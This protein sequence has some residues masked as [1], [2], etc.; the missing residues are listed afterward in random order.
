MA[1]YLAAQGSGSKYIKFADPAV[2]AVLMAKGV[3]SDGIG[4]TTADAE[5]VTDIGTWFNSNTAIEYFN[6]F[7]K[8]TCVTKLGVNNTSTAPFYKCT[9]LKQIKL[10]NS[11]TDISTSSFSGCTSLELLP[12]LSKVTYL[13][14]DA[15]GGCTSMDG[16]VNMPNV[17]NDFSSAEFAQTKISKVQSLGQIKRLSYGSN[18]TTNGTFTQ[19]PSLESV[20][21][22]ETLTSI[23]QYCF[24]NCAKL[25]NIVFPQSLQTISNN[26]FQGCTALEIPDL[27]LPNLTS[28]GKNAFYG[29]KIKKIS[30]LGKITALP[31][32]SSSTQNFGDKSVLEEVVLPETLTSLPAYSFYEYANLSSI[33]LSKIE[34]FERD[35]MSGCTSLPSVLVLENAKDFGSGVFILCTSLERVELPNVVTIADA[36]NYR[37]CFSGCNN[38]AWL[39][40]GPNCTKIGSYLRSYSTTTTPLSI[41][42]EAVTP[43]SLGNSPFHA[44]G[45]MGYIYVPDA[46]VDAYKAATNWA[47]FSDVIKPMSELNG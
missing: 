30:D 18:N 14:S 19:C 38:L 16:V 45:A 46:S 25:S 35:S 13:G 20:V 22:P 1:G 33:N 24:Y 15:F 31:A 42:C 12:D 5:A 39:R 11:I 4:I 10:P 32:A 29:V 47:Q 40:I 21:L 44:G 6:E 26:A 23:G 34:T 27:S 28:L 37:G 41:I 9:A 3:S 2:E 36:I 7:E 43:P 8:F 17:T